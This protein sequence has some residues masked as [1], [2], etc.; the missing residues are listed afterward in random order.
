MFA[1]MK[2]SGRA[3]RGQ[4]GLRDRPP[5]C[6]SLCFSYA[7]FPA[8]GHAGSL[9]ILF[10][11]ELFFLHFCGFSLEHNIIL[12]RLH[13]NWGSGGWGGVWVNIPSNLY[14]QYFKSRNT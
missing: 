5:D 6:L 4:M 14:T 12:W 7:G 9:Y 2:C 3:E 10:E 11:L 8:V 1:L 13:L